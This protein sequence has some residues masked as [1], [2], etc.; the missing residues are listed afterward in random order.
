MKRLFLLSIL[1][2]IFYNY[3]FSKIKPTQLTCEYL[4]NPSV[5]DVN[6][7]RLAW[8][9]IADEG[10][11][12][13]TQTAWQVRVA[14]SKSQFNNP[15]LWDSKKVAGNQSIRIKYD[16]EKLASRQDCWWRTGLVLP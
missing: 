12:G 7:P 1:F 9:N 16:G 13:Q 3:S 15:D 4:E 14:S 5:V 6:Q 2:F 10:E 11:R 8:I